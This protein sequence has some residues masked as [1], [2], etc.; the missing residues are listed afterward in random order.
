MFFFFFVYNLSLS[1]FQVEVNTTL[2]G[3]GEELLTNKQPTVEI[4]EGCFD[5]IDGY[6][7][8]SVKCIFNYDEGALAK[9]FRHL[10]L[11]C[12]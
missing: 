3:P 10:T 11:Y 8:P 7:N 12:F 6:Y 2:K 5:T 4:P 1:R 9:Y